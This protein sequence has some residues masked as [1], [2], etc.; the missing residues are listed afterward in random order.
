MRFIIKD[1]FIEI[2]AN[3]DYLKSV[4]PDIDELLLEIDHTLNTH[5][6]NTEVLN[7]INQNKSTISTIDNHLT[8]IK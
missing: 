4:M 7:W 1:M 6:N 2:S 3:I 8:K 5:T